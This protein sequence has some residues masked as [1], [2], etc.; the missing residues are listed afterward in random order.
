M[1]D[2]SVTGCARVRQSNA[3]TYCTGVGLKDAKQHTVV[4]FGSATHDVIGGDSRNDLS[5]SGFPD[6]NSRDRFTCDVLFIFWF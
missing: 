5:S 4:S 6:K 2:A 1:V 3:T